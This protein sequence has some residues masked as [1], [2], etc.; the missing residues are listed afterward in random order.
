M[1]FRTLAILSASAL[2]LAACGK[3]AEPTAANTMT[4]DNTTLGADAPL[5]ANDTA[6][7]TAASPA[8]TFVNTAA[9]SDA[10]EIATSKAALEKSSSAAVKKYANQMIEAHTAST[11]KLKSTVAAMPTPLTPDPKLTAEQQAKLDALT[12]KS[13]ADFDTT[14]VAEQQAA[15][16]QTLD[17]LRAYAASGDVPA[18]KTFASGL[19]PTVAAHL[20]MAKS[21]KP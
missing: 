4:V 14:Y 10:F 19:V 20:N 15:H 13:G 5:T 3:P 8:Q 6:L 16:Q 18:L 12:A 1:S 17:A 11:A 2:T 7:A 9:A 21:L